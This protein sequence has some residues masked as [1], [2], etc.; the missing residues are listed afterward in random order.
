MKAYVACILDDHPCTDTAMSFVNSD[1]PY[2][3]LEEGSHCALLPV[4]L[5]YILLA[6]GLSLS[7]R[8]CA[9]V[10]IE[11][12]FR[13]FYYSMGSITVRKAWVSGESSPVIKDSLT[14]H[15]WFSRPGHPSM[16]IGLAISNGTALHFCFTS[17]IMLFLCCCVPMDVIFVTFYTSYMVYFIYRRLFLILFDNF[18]TACICIVC[19]VCCSHFTAIVHQFTCFCKSQV[20]PYRYMYVNCSPFEVL[21]S[22]SFSFFLSMYIA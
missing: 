2:I 14:H 15:P 19:C 10:D 4:G 13:R 3:P 22:F 21:F 18:Y 1:C 8:F 11:V 17:Y 20:S 9:V 16:P 6:L 5:C 7:F 12:C